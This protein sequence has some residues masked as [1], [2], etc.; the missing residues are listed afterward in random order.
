[1]GSL[2]GPLVAALLDD[3]TTEAPTLD[4][5]CAKGDFSVVGSASPGRRLA[6]VPGVTVL[7]HDQECAAEKRRKRKRGMAE[8]PPTRVVQ[9]N[10]LSVRPV[11]T[12]F[13]KKDRDS[14]VVV[15]P[16]L[17]LPEG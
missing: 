3:S 11:D 16:G 6:G 8:T 9:S 12:E 17:L 15:Q 4:T 1:M 10:C 5:G 13:G 7:I 2:Q 14:P